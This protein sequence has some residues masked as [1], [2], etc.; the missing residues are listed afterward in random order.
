MQQHGQGDVAQHLA[1]AQG[2]QFHEHAAARHG[3]AALAHQTDHGIQGAAGGQHVVHDEDA[4]LRRQGI[5]VQTQGIGAV[6]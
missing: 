1:A 6:F 4:I 3:G 2:I 5:L